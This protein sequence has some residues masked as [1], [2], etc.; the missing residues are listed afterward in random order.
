MANVLQW[1]QSTNS[2]SVSGATSVTPVVGEGIDNNFSVMQSFQDGIAVT[3]SSTLAGTSSGSVISS[4]EQRGVTKE[5]TFLVNGYVNDTSTDQ[6][7]TF[8]V[9]FTQQVAVTFNN[10]GLT[11]TVSLTGFTITAPGSTTA[12]N[13]VIVV[14]GG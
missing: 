14:K 11:V 12:Y 8:P 7:I 13:G 1:N 4:Q 5:I 9:A 10:T 6:S 2:F 3:G